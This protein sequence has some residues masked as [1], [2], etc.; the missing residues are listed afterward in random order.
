MAKA[1]QKQRVRQNKK[2]LRTHLLAL[3]L[4]LT[5][6]VLL[7]LVLSQQ[8]SYVSFHTTTLLSTFIIELLCYRQM[9]MLARPRYDAVRSLVFSS[10]SIAFGR[11]NE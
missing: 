8:T 10:F 11:D 9:A 3:S 2:V 6:H 4:A 1:N 7:L 5:S